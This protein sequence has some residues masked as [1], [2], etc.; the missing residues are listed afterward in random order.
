MSMK[1]TPSPP[2]P[3]PHIIY[4]RFLFKEFLSNVN[5]MNSHDINQLAKFRKLMATYGSYERIGNLCV[6]RKKGNATCV[7]I[8]SKYL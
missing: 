1:S 7:N 2:T 8:D 4:V 5:I 3:P 6:F